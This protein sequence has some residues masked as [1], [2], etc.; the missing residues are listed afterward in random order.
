MQYWT[1]IYKEIAGRINDNLPEIRWIDLW[2]D[3]VNFLSEELPFDTPSVFI[4]F[5]TVSIDDRSALVQDCDT[6]IDMYLF[7]ETFSDTYTGSY[8]QD[9]AIEFLESL[10]RLNALF[11]GKNGNSYSPMRRVDMRR[12]DSGGS[13]NL[14]RISFQCMIT[15]YSAQNIFT[16]T[17]DKNREIEIGNGDIPDVPEEIPLFDL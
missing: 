10:T 12:E 7:Y 2:H 11:H 8:N 5:S 3:Q 4:G 15:D 1:E 6:Q 17:E 13:G 16:E 9:R 14:Y